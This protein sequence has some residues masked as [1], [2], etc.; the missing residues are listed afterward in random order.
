MQVLGLVGSPRKGGNTDILVDAILEGARG[1]GHVVRKI[2]LRDH[3]IGPCVDCR[4]CKQG[5]NVCIVE[6]GMQQVYPLLDA[7]DAIV[8]GTPVYWYGPSGHMKQMFDRLRPYFA[9]GRLAGKK[10]L[11]VSVA[12]DGPGEGDLLTEMFRRSLAALKIEFAGHV[13]GT[14]YDPKDVL[15]DRPAME[16]AAALGAAL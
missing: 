9:S 13:I 7:A 12:G 4:G 1:R 14:G 3:A 8:F 5:A 15:A 11:L 10:A 6:D 2:H 16:R